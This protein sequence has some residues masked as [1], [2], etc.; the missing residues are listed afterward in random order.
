LPLRLSTQVEAA[1][2]AKRGGV[3]TGALVP[4]RQNQNFSNFFYSFPNKHLGK[5]PSYL[6]AVF[7]QLLRW[8][9]QLWGR[10]L[11]LSP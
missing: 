7:S 2:E 9:G 5:F 4:I 3:R 8:L 10:L 1:G 6:Q 11:V